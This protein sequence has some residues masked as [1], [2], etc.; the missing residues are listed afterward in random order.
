MAH[1]DIYALGYPG[2]NYGG[3]QLYSTSGTLSPGSYGEYQFDYEKEFFG[4]AGI[5]LNYS[6]MGW[7]ANDDFGS[8]G[9]FSGSGVWISHQILSGYDLRQD[10][11][12]GLVSGANTSVR[13]ELAPGII[14]PISSVYWELADALTIANADADNFG[15]NVLISSENETEFSGTFFHEIIHGSSSA[16]R[17]YGLGGDDEIFG[18]EGSDTLVGGTGND[19]LHGGDGYDTVLLKGDMADYRISANDDGSFSIS[20]VHSDK[21]DGVDQ[22][23]EIELVRFGDG[24]DI[25]LDG[26]TV[27][28]IPSDLVRGE[29]NIIA[30]DWMRSGDLSF[31][32]T[33]FADGTIVRPSDGIFNDGTFTLNAGFSLYPDQ[34]VIPVGR[35]TFDD[36]ELSSVTYTIQDNPA[37]EDAV[38]FSINGGPLTK[39]VTIEYLSIGD[40]VDRIGGGLWGDPHLLTYDNVGYDFQAAGEFVLVHAKTGDPYIVQA[41]FVQ[42]SSAVSVTEAIGTLVDGHTVTVEVDGAGGK[43]TVNGVVTEVADGA[44]VSV[45]AGTISRDGDRIQIDHGNGDITLVAAFTTFLSVAP[46]PSL[47]RDPGSLEGLL[48]NGNGDPTDDLQLADGTVLTTPVPVETLYGDFAD[49]WRVQPGNRYLPGD[50]EPFKAPDRIITIDSLPQELRAEA[51]AAVDAMGITNP[52]LREAAIL[53][54]ALTG[55]EEFIETGQLAEQIFDPLVDTVAVDPV[56]NPA[57]ILQAATLTVDEDDPAARVVEFTVS[58]AATVGDVTIDYTVSGTGASPTD[59]DDFVGQIVAGS[60]LIPDGVESQT[61]TVEIAD[62]AVFEGTETFSVSIA[63]E[64][65]QAANYEVLVS[66]VNLSITDNDNAAPTDIALSPGDV[67]ENSTGNTVV[68]A[69]LATDPNADDTH[70]FTF[71]DDAGGLFALDGSNIIVAL[72]A[73]SDFEAASEHTIEVR[74]MD[75]GGLSFD[76]TLNVTVNDLPDSFLGGPGNDTILGD[77]GDNTIEGYAGHDIISSG[78]GADVIGLGQGNDLLTGPLGFFFGDTVKDFGMN[79]RMFFEGLQLTRDGIGVTHGSAILD[80]DDDGDG[81]SDGSFTLEGDFSGGDFMAARLETGTQ[82]TFEN[83]LASLQNKQAVN[84]SDINGII[85]AEFL[86]GHNVTDMTVTFEANASAGFDNTIGYYE[87][88]P[89]GNLLNVTILAVNAKTTSG[90]IDINVGDPNNDIGF[91]LVQDGANK[92]AGSEFF[93][94]DFEFV[95]DGTGG[96]DLASQGAVLTGVN[97]FFSHDATLNPDGMEHVLSGVSD[98][99]EGALRIGFEDLMR[100]GKSDDDFQD[101]I[102]YVDIA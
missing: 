83:F 91:F 5:D 71:L 74:A 94:D 40:G 44:S 54:Y 76:K 79:D 65:D 88:D 9:G 86:N 24:Q 46:Q 35:A 18:K 57:I 34:G 52:I 37:V 81:S 93:A 27:L 21:S 90:P 11:L 45:G 72:G 66:S 77:A 70:T 31:S 25:E 56:S 36:D 84:G 19:S 98:D 92:I 97:V 53:D 89:S 99:G 58:R 30:Q 1:G 50:P 47:A 69:L 32:V 55:D 4:L 78:R 51:E 75:S 60:V 13:G 96:F 61:F 17:L 80:I 87:I 49:S 85:N 3:E 43:I 2:Y 100:N 67:D 26:L 48:G 20:H 16:D 33:L 64:P 29:G 7:D 101:V 10:L 82:V 42:I 23:F 102:L 22:L 39:E 38:F 28:E 14:A 73:Q 6:M 63:V 62:D 95:S 15:V 68:G 8:I 12:I 41:R 59:A